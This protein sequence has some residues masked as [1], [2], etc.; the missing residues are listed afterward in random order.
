MT[1]IKIHKKHTLQHFVQ[2]KTLPEIKNLSYRNDVGAN[3]NMIP[4][5]AKI[6]C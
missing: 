6:S 5:Q 1:F 4:G 3:D 2:D